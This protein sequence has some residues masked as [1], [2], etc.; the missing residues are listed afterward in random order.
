MPGQYFKIRHERFFQH[1]P[2]F[3][4]HIHRT[5]RRY[6]TYAVDKASSN[7]PGIIETGNS[8]YNGVAIH[9]LAFQTGFLVK[10]VLLHTST[11]TARNTPRVDYLDP[12]FVLRCP[13]HS[14]WAEHVSSF[15][16]F[17]T[18]HLSITLIF[19]RRSNLILS[20]FNQV[21]PFSDN[22]RNII[23]TETN[24]HSNKSISLGKSILTQGL[25]EFH[26]CA[27]F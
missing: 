5:F 7:K 1:P 6:I 14:Y 9:P 13:L 15:L 19:C 25:P 17:P 21:R 27:Y 11:S 18:V 12:K 4:I 22:F 10:Q 16:F 23:W 3:T 2:K 26:C 24:K 20:C 8:A